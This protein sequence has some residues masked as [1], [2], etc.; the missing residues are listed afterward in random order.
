MADYGMVVVTVEGDSGHRLPRQET[1]ADE[2]PTL[3][4]GSIGGLG[5]WLRHH[6]FQVPESLLDS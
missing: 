5:I 4:A 3:A 2:L 1:C 6:A